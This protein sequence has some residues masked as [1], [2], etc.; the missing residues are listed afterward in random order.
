[1]DV[2]TFSP[3]LIGCASHV[4]GT[5]LLLPDLSSRTLVLKELVIVGIGLNPDLSPS[6]CPVWLV[7]IQLSCSHLCSAGDSKVLLNV[8]SQNALVPPHKFLLGIFP[9]FYT[10]TSQSIAMQQ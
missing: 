4:N 5:L 9:S 6:T 10:F 2:S 3:A 1:M 8:G 7:L